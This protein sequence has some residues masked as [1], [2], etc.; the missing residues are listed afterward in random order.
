MPVAKLNTTGTLNAMKSEEGNDSL[1][2]FIR[3]TTTGKEPF[4]SFSRPGESP[5]Q[6]I[7]LLHAL[8]QPD[9]P[10]WPLLTPLKV[11]MQ[12]CEKCSR[13]FFSPINY[14][15]HIRVH[16]RSLNVDK[17]SH[18]NRDLLAA[19]W[20]KLSLEQAKEIVALKDVSV[21]ELPGS[22]VIRAL[23]SSL[24]KPGIWT[25][26]QVY[27]KA[28]ST[29]LDIIQAKPSR[30]PISSHELF[31]IL[32]DAS[33]RTFLCAGT[34]ESVQKY[35]FEGEAA[36]NGL[37][38][39]NLVACTSFLFEY[40]LVKA[41]VADKDAEALR[42][43]KLLVAE[44]EAAQ[45]R[46][47]QKKLRQKEQRAREQLNECKAELNITI[48]AL[49]QPLSAEASGPPSP[50]DFSPN[51]PDLP[52]NIAS[53]P[54]PIQFP[55]K[56]IDEDIEAQIDF[57]GEHIDQGNFQTIE[58][59][60]M[61][62]NGHRHLATNRW[63]VPNSQRGGQNGIHVSQNLQ[64]SKPEPTQKLG[65]S[66]GRGNPLNGSK[67]WTKKCK[68][69]NEGESWRRRVQSESGNQ[70][71]E[72]SCEVMIGS[73]SVTLRNS[74]TQKQ[75]AHLDKATDAMLK[76]SI[77]EK[78]IK[79]DVQFGMNRV[80]AKLCKPVSPLPV[81]S[82]NKDS[83]DGLLSEKVY[84]QTVSGERCV[85]SCSMEDNDC[86]NSGKHCHVLSDTQ[87]GASFFSSIAAKEF[88]AQRWK[89]AISADHVRLVLSPELESPSCPDVQ[90]D[91]S[92]KALGPDSNERSVL[93]NA[94]NRPV[95]ST[96]GHV[97]VKVRTKPD[98]RLKRSH[99]LQCTPLA[100][101]VIAVC[102]GLILVKEL[103][104]CI[105]AV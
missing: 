10:G 25:L 15:R 57:S 79:S 98:K 104:F 40:Q 48:D 17:E 1:D 54:E 4:L 80:A 96:S 18:K 12:K 103:D 37:E 14:R 73:I 76:N 64:S 26:P 20:D 72:N 43:Q 32:D 44:E 55:S 70:T 62:A 9:L 63:Q 91:C 67:I 34:A 49:E 66:R 21:K 42:C 81:E 59:Q 71:E 105:S 92:M 68:A 38:L 56:E 3:Q 93:G 23:A 99:D 28:G 6:W 84:D 78:P 39:R 100:L 50:S 102:E 27:V 77:S 85:Q 74:I 2:T 31:S 41:W 94:E 69:E 13:E 36:K 83:E 88:L 24:R 46:K 75:D 47:K 61:A 89:E 35:V 29:L 95:S 22:S 19:F 97:Q 45:K 52:A 7:Q 51:S 5:V 16:R 30:L 86:G 58:T 33:E 90:D 60:M 82:G 53:C 101:Q 11:Q 8:D 65:P 87:P